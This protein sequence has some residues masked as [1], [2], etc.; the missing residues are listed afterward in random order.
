MAPQEISARVL[1]KM[2]KTAEAYLGETVT[3]AVITVPAYFNDSQR[4]A[5]KDAGRIAGLDV[6]RIINEPDRGRARLRLGQE[7]R[8]RKIAVVRPRRRH[9]RRV[10]HRDR[11]GRRREAVRGAGPPTAT[12]SSAAR[13]STSAS[14][15]TSS[16][17]STR[18][19]G[20][21]LRKDPAR[22]A[23]PRRTRPSAPRSSFRPRSRPRS[24]CRTSPPTPSGPKHLNIKL[25]RAKLEALV[26][27]LIR[28]TIEP[29]KIALHRSPACAPATSASDPGRRPDPHAEGAGGGDR[30]LRQ[31]A[32][33]GRQPGRGR[34]HRRRDPGRRARGTSR[35]CCCST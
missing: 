34:R 5:T 13:T 4:Q 33:Q 1:E 18:S 25:T 17:S 11:R 14:S 10:D 22:P 21:D 28:K 31:G 29:C 23:A 12:P 2:K 8:D 19:R 26:D 9:L 24:T 6:K 16:T 27:D 20:I 30:V 3:E 35:T 32:A 7:G 15:T